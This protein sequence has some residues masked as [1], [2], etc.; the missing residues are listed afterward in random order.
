MH[1]ARHHA[2]WL[3]LTEVAGP[4]LSLPVLLR[5]FPEG[6]DKLDSAVTRD[7]R[8]AY[9]EWLD[10]AGSLRPDPAIHRAWV[11]Y[12][13]HTVLDWPRD[14]LAAGPAVPGTLAVTVPEHGET[15][16]P[17][18][19]L[20]DPETRAPRLLLQRLPAGQDPEKALPGARWKASP[21]TRMIDLLRGTDVRLGLVTNGE[22]WVLVHAPRGETSGQATWYAAL[23]GEEPVTLQAFCSLLAA[24]RFFGVAASDTLAALLTESAANQQEVTEQLGF[25]VRRAVEVLVQRLDAVDKDWHRT[26]LAGVSEPRLYEAALTVMMRLVF[27]FSA[28]ERGMLLLGDP[29]YDAYYAV[30]TLRAQLREAADQHGEEVLER[31]R[32]A[33]SRLLGTFRLVYGGAAHDRLHLPAY[34][35]RLFDPDAFPFLEGR[36]TGTR[37]TETQ[38][39]PLPID[40]RTVLHLLEALQILQ[41]KVPGGPPEPRRLSFRAL[42]I[43]QIGHVYEGLLDHTAV[44]AT[45]PVL[46]LTGGKDREPE[47]ALA[48]LERLHTK[49]EAAV[50]KYL[51]EMTGRSTVTLRKALA[52]GIE[53]QDF[54]RFRAA[55]DNDEGLL[56][57]VRPFA[58]LVRRDSFGVPL[59]VTPGSVYV[60]AGTDR[61]QSGTHYTPRS[62]TEPLV[63]HALDPLVYRGM[64][65]GTPP[66]PETLRGP[67]EILAL[68]ICDMAMGSGA[69]LV[70]ACRYLAE[71]LVDAWG[72]AEEGSGIR[73]QGSGAGDPNS[74]IHVEGS[75]IRDQ[76]SGAGDPDS[77]I[78]NPKSKIRITP[79]GLPATGDLAEQALP[80]DPEERL[81]LARRLVCDRCLYGVDKNPLAVEMAKLSLWLVTLQKDRPFTFLDHALRPGDSLLGVS[82]AQLLQ[83]SLTPADAHQLTWW[84]GPVEAALRTAIEWRQR[85]ESLPTV[86]KAD[87]DDKARMLAEAEE[88]LTLLRL[89]GDLLTASALA[90]EP[91]ERE[92][93]RDGWLPR[94]STLLAIRRG[95]RERGQG[96][97]AEAETVADWDALQTEAAAL[98]GATRPFH[99]SL[100]FPEVFQHR[101]TPM[102]GQ[103]VTLPATGEQVIV[104]GEDH[105]AGFDAIIGNPPFR[106]GKLITGILG[107]PYRDYLV[108]VLA[109]NRTGSADLCAYF[110]LR[111]GELIHFGGTMAL[112][113]TNTIA[114]GDTREVGLD[115]LVTSSW[116]IYRAVP[117]RRWPG[118]ASLEVSH[119]WLHRGAWFGNHYLDDVL[120]NGIN[121]LLTVPSAVQGKPYRLKSNL[122]KVF[123]GSIVLGM[124]FS[125]T[126]EEGQALIAKDLCNRDVIFPYLNGEDLNSRYDQ[127]PS[128]CVINF[129]DWPLEQA[130]TYP[131]CMAI[132]REKV[133]PERD[134]LAMKDDPS[135]KGYARLW[136]QYGRRGLD[137]YTTISGLER[138]LVVAATSRTLAFAFVPSNIVFSNALYVFSLEV[139]SYL[140][141]L[142]S[143]FHETWVREYASSM[144]GDLRYTPT[145]CFET[146]PFPESTAGLDA[147][148]QAYYE[149]RQAIMQARQEGLTKTYNRFHNPAETAADIARLRELHMAMDQAVAAAYGWADL[150]LGHGFHP[151][152]QGL[153]YTIREA[154]RRTVLDR[155]LAL[156]HARYAAEVAAG[157]HD[158]GAKGRRGKAQARGAAAQGSLF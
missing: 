84:S 158:V 125:L 22:S 109:S 147:I 65:E 35:G 43:E 130:E 73:D 80:R 114:Q 110:F 126:P 24:G 1:I 2:E 88:A 61:R 79:Y 95:Q 20:L 29:L 13:L 40:N 107:T 34:G 155:L 90:P 118:T 55:C 157:L 108:E 5:A 111:A 7:V 30:S 131:D 101:A 23:W 81:A 89:G 33:W 150:D 102:T 78:Q 77:K 116:V 53:L 70:Q 45:A 122:D 41:V 94:F 75:G 103:A 145:D 27:L 68:K 56:E 149:H 50:L 93:L 156:N 120:V 46:G 25:Q 11:D 60:T 115:Q 3:A 44:R 26:L 16:R 134:K 42:D 74:K 104:P 128:R 100:E 106:G 9:E 39:R 12:V 19:V 66:S 38:A 8:L 52:A 153:R 6:L 4:F 82:T 18:G 14:L 143:V 105:E 67:A 49:G 144:K 148:G 76:G 85:I 17:D 37:W 57:R 83:W 99:W 58:G 92:R 59:V 141:L 138:V 135:A 123:Q 31:R 48:E 140:A 127:S 62:L 21:V 10:N 63:Q 51:E 71:K 112:L 137:L 136:W 91:K 132:V 119:L 87:T 54:A 86:T 64:A 129:R 113:A 47:V 151:T 124:G 72:R 28:E 117:S 15:L 146:F 69:F 36:A 121:P 152:K 32:D 139:S 133:K 96:A 97:A 142:Q 98:L 154:A